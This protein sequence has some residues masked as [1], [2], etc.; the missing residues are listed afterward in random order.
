MSDDFSINI[1]FEVN[2]PLTRI[3]SYRYLGKLVR[4][5]TYIVFKYN[6]D[7]AQVSLSEILF[8]LVIKEKYLLNI[9][10]T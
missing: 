8:S 6:A 3:S 4:V 7:F 1:K 9:L 5:I 2:L 10:V